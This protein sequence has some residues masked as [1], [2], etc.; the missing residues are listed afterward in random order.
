M[1]T[2][3]AHSPED[4]EDD[5]VCFNC[6]AMGQ[7]EAEDQLHDPAVLRVASRSIHIGGYMEGWPPLTAA[8]LLWRIAY[9]PWMVWTGHVWSKQIYSY[10]R[11]GQFHVFGGRRYINAHLKVVE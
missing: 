5:G 6:Y 10:L 4:I 3:H 7:H 11:R 8:R 1:V 9:L 2:A